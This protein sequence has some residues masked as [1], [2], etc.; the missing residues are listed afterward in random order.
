MVL[1]MKN[2]SPEERTS[3]FY[4]PEYKVWSSMIQ[5]CTNPNATGY[6]WYGARGVK[7]C[8]RWRVF[9]NFYKDMGE[10]PKGMTVDRIDSGKGYE[11]SNCRWATQKQQQNN[12]TINLLFTAFGKTQTLAQW[13][14]EIKVPYPTLYNRMKKAWD[15]ELALSQP[16]RKYELYKGGE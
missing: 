16:S 13:A 7:V 1:M 5:R 4:K 15:V 6:Q 11:P 2:K 14:D 12:K 10:R 3:N 9:A 8:E